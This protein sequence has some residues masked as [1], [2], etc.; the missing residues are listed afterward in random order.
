MSDNKNNTPAAAGDV[1]VTLAIHTYEKAQV[2]QTLL[3]T[4]GVESILQNVNQ[5]QP[6]VSAGVRVKIKERDLPRA[7]AILE[8]SKWNLSEIKNELKEVD[9]QQDPTKMP[10]VLLAVDFSSFTANILQVGFKF[11]MRRNLHVRLL[12]AAFVPYFSPLPMAGQDVLPLSYQQSARESVDLAHRKMKE[13]EAHIGELQAKGELPDVPFRG[14]V[15]EG[16][17]DEVILNYARDHRPTAVIMGTRGASK[18]AEDLIGSVAA[19]VIDAA[20][21]PVLVVPENLA[22]TDLADLKNV[23]VATGFDQRDLVL[24]DRMI[25][26]MAPNT[27][28]YHIFNISRSEEG[29][30]ETRL[31]LISEYHKEHYP[32]AQ[33]SFYELDRGDFNEA[34]SKFVEEKSISLIVVNTYRRSLIAKFFRP[35]MARRMLF[36]SGMP[37]LVMHSNSFR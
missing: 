26:L 4:N 14:L 22:V 7:L 17:A 21:V 19:E 36:H 11:A 33:I 27:P 3:H 9:K 5:I 2:L 20:R 37:L 31:R 16:A 34:L 10:F 25:S 13:L 6:V 29:I 24:F 15:R 8:D 23:A 18:H 35:G 32:Q 28:A 12:H 1:L 30:G